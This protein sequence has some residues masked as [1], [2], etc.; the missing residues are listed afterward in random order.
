MYVMNN[1]KDLMFSMTLFF[2]ITSMKKL[3]YYNLGFWIEEEINITHFTSTW[4]CNSGVSEE[5][6]PYPLQ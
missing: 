3:T 2:C 5:K 4:Q 6:L 1:T